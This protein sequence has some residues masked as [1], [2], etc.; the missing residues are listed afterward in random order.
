[1]IGFDGASM[2]AYN[3]AYKDYKADDTNATKLAN[4]ISKANAMKFQ[5][6]GDFSIMT[7]MFKADGVGNEINDFLD[8]TTFFASYSK[9]KTNPKE[10]HIMLGSADKQSGHSIWI[11]AQM[12]CLLT[13]DGRFGV[14]WNKGSKYWRSMT[15][16]EDTMIGSKIAVRGTATEFYWL[17]PLTKALSLNIRHTKLKYDYT[18]SNA[19][20]GADGTPTEI[21]QAQGNPV[22]EA[23]DTRVSIRYQF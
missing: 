8:S 15:Y 21:S 17:K 7:A 10:G 23:T 16:G 20:F 1:M 9:S 6:V 4:Y 22:K 12:P 11:G 13:E 19:F 2:N 5:D 18:G 3:N 14:E